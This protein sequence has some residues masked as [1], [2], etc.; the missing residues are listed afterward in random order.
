VE[1]GYEKVK[2]IWDDRFESSYGFWRSF[3]EGTVFAFLGCGDFEQGFA[4]VRCSQC[5]AEFLVAMS[6]KRRGFCASCAAKRAAIFGAFLREEVLEEVPHAMWTLTI[7][8][9]LRRYF[10]N[11]RKL[12]GKLA[13]AGFETVQE[14]MIE[15]VGGDETLR[16]GMVAVIQ[17]AGDLMEWNP[18]VHAI[19]T[20]GGW[21]PDGSWVPIPYIDTKAA[22][23]LFRSKVIA[24]LKAE[25]LL[26][27]E[28]IQMLDTWSSHRVKMRILG[29][30]RC[31]GAA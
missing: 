28:R 12:L 20:R 21:N 26:S 3:V 22:E 5:K 2:G 1:S 8:K 27:D 16:T 6:C 18:H 31:Y 17:T 29:P 25:G 24:F 19:A 15:A 14:L 9:L 11:H 23:L 30:Q 4:R 7:P 13:R 10:L